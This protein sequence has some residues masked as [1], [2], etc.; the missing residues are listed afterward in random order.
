MLNNEN[1]VLC[2]ETSGGR[3]GWRGRGGRQCLRT[4]SR[5][6]ARQ[7]II[8]AYLVFYYLPEKLQRLQAAKDSRMECGKDFRQSIQKEIE[9]NKLKK[10]LR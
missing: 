6:P 1:A 4:G 5:T 7:Q 10:E 3:G 2:K 8:R 9:E